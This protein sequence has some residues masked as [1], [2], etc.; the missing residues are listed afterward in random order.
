MYPE[1]DPESSPKEASAFFRMRSDARSLDFRKQPVL[2]IEGQWLPDEIDSFVELN[3][4]NELWANARI[5]L[6]ERYGYLWD[7]IEKN[8]V[9]SGMESDAIA[10]RKIH[11][12]EILIALNFGSR[13]ANEALIHFTHAQ[14]D[15]PNEFGNWARVALR[16]QE[17]PHA[18]NHTRSVEAIQKMNAILVGADV[19]DPSLTMA[20]SAAMKPI[21]HDIMQNLWEQQKERFPD[22]P[23]LKN[24][25]P[26][27]DHKE[28]AAFLVHVLKP[29]IKRAGHLSDRLTEELVRVLSAGIAVHDQLDDFQFRLSDKGVKTSESDG[30]AVD[31]DTPKVSA[32]GLDDETLFKYYQDG[33]VD[34]MT[35]TGLDRYRILRAQ[36]REIVKRK[37]K[38]GKWENGDIFGMYGFGQ[39]ME[40]AHRGLI[41]QAIAPEQQGSMGDVRIDRDRMVAWDSLFNLTDIWE[42]IIPGEYA[43]IRKEKVY[44]SLIRVLFNPKGDM[45]VA[46]SP[47]PLLNY[48]LSSWCRAMYEYRS[49]VR[50]L[51]NSPFAQNDLFMKFIGNTILYNML[52]A[53]KLYR[54]LAKGEEGLGAL[55]KIQNERMRMATKKALSKANADPQEV[56]AVMKEVGAMKFQEIFETGYA[57]LM[58]PTYGVV[59]VEIATRLRRRYK[60]MEREFNRVRANMRIKMRPDGTESE[61]KAHQYSAEEREHMER[62]FNEAWQRICVDLGIPDVEEQNTMRENMERIPPPRLQDLYPMLPNPGYPDSIGKLSDAKTVNPLPEEV[63]VHLQRSPFE[64]AADAET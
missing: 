29:Y 42:M 60:A 1:L 61:R 43:V 40:A 13:I 56:R 7:E 31:H 44:R 10:E 26:K 3:N 46:F 37:I 54:E 34:Q 15:D 57:K 16:N 22:D 5:D 9:E 39:S 52:Q 63:R 32:V 23:V 51:M 38:D 24:F 45:A 49:N 18:D 6:E 12:G 8:L 19:M 27:D 2:A 30:H 58:Q 11:T 36:Q 59:G 28:A 4:S 20:V 53:Q 14:T 35:L 64:P 47:T 21:F 55:D 62:N 41:Q 50:V 33:T 48:D 25:D 17:L